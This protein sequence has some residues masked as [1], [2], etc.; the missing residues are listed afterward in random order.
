[1]KKTF[2]TLLVALTFILGMSFLNSCSNYSKLIEGDW[3]FSENT[4]EEEDGEA[5][6]ITTEFNLKLHGDRITFGLAILQEGKEIYSYSASGKYKFEQGDFDH[7]SAIGIIQPTFDLNTLDLKFDEASLSVADKAQIKDD[8]LNF[9]KEF[10]RQV[11]KAQDKSSLLENQFYGLIVLSVD[12][13]DLV[14]D[15]SGE[16]ATFIKK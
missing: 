3:T 1:M 5:V 8:A 7:S 6:K 9:Y 4:F 11:D 2:Q 14:L 16:K 15:F 13:T 12:E 10:N